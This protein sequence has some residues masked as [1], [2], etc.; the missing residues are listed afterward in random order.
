MAKGGG[1]INS[2]W[3][4]AVVTSGWPKPD[5]ATVVRVVTAVSKRTAPSLR[6]ASP[7]DGSICIT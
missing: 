5:T 4:R 7:T 2:A 3:Q 1:H 6:R